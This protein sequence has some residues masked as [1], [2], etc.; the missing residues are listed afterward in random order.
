MPEIELA[1]AD[2]EALSVSEA[3]TYVLELPVIVALTVG[4][5]LDSSEAREDAALDKTLE[6]S[7]LST[8]DTAV[9]VAV[10][11]TLE[12]SELSEDAR[13]VRAL[14]A[15]AVTEAGT[16]ELSL[17]TLEASESAEDPAEDTTLEASDA[18]EETR[19]ERSSLLDAVDEEPVG[20]AVV[21][22]LAL[23]GDVAEASLAEID[24][25]LRDSVLA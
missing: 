10:A 16:R 23:A 6:N 24:P 9:S 13:L 5:L 17:A 12:S 11:A 18:T 1:L 14:E 3:A 21:S 7:E 2:P 25:A 15:P 4:R 22:A 8:L 20:A 19:L